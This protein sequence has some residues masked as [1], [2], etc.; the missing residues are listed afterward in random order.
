MIKNALLA[1]FSFLFALILLEIGVRWTSLE[2]RHVSTGPKEDWALVPE[3]VWTEHHPELGWFHQKNKQAR[4]QKDPIDTM[5]I[6]NSEGL[7]SLREYQ[8]AVPAGKTRIMAIGDSFVM[9]FGVENQEAFPAVM[10]QEHGD[11]EVMNFGVA[12]YGLDQM[13][14]IVRHFAPRYRPNVVLVGIFPED[15]W[16]STRAF[17][18]TGHAKPYFVL[19]SDGKLNLKN[20]P[21]PPP[22][23][24]RTNQFP[25]VIEHSPIEKI[26]LQSMVYRMLKRGWIKVGKNLKWIDPDTTEEWILG[27]ALLKALQ[28]E[29]ME[30]GARPVFM[31]IPPD[32]WMHDTG[33]TSLHK[34]LLRLADKEPLIFLDLTP[35]FREAVA[36]QDLKTYYIENDGHWTPEGHRL[37]A[38]A[39]QSFL[40]KEGLVASEDLAA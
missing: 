3:R 6:M 11:W 37:A 35:I 24:L 16:R 14:M 13:L 29:I 12:G 5:I 27:R 39:I 32:R 8:E 36:Q 40:L 1:L 22:F 15:F 38:E 20:V 17:A 7:R 28:D 9:G 18:D 21:V 19:S 23:V 30:S 2:T 34:S 33:K 4:L 25:E 31:L 26:L 10:E